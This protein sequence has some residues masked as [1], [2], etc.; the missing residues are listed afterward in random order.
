M[1]DVETQLT[2]KEDYNQVSMMQGM[3]EQIIKEFEYVFTR[4][5]HQKR[6]KNSNEG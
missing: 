2:E 4:M 1:Y 5:G 3:H 6:T